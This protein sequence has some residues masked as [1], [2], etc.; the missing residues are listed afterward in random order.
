[1]NL[2]I[3]V[4]RLSLVG[5][6]C[7]NTVL[8][9]MLDSILNENDRGLLKLGIIKLI[10]EKTKFFICKMIEASQPFHNLRNNA[11]SDRVL[12]YKFYDNLSDFWY[13]GIGT[14]ILELWADRDILN[15]TEKFPNAYN[16]HIKFLTCLIPKLVMREYIPT[17]EDYVQYNLSLFEDK[18]YYEDEQ[19]WIFHVV[20]VLP[21]NHHYTKF[22]AEYITSVDS[23]TT[24]I[25]EIIYCVDVKKFNKNLLVQNQLTNFFSFHLSQLEILMHCSNLLHTPSPS[26]VVKKIAF[27]NLE[28]LDTV[29]FEHFGPDFYIV[30]KEILKRLVEEYLLTSAQSKKSKTNLEFIYEN[31]EMLGQQI[32]KLAVF[33]LNLKN[34]GFIH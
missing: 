8:L 30:N 27:M 12:E 21:E 19:R 17:T 15:I 20:E 5:D 6:E 2:C 32:M 34:A 13:N 11:R 31:S 29:R 7:I 33:R 22:L 26:S 28:N 24:S 1:V 3:K 10:L 4:G 25:E 16:A 23:L 18:I 14:D 9:A